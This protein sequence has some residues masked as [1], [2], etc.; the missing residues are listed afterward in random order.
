MWVGSCIHIVCWFF[1]YSGSFAIAF[2]IF[3][4][5]PCI[6][7]VL[8]ISLS[9]VTPFIILVFFTHHLL[10]YSFPIAASP[11][12][13]FLSRSRLISPFLS[14]LLYRSK[15]LACLLHLLCWILVVFVHLGLHLACSLHLLCWILFV[16][17]HWIFDCFVSVAIL[18]IK[19]LIKHCGRS[20]NIVVY[21]SGFVVSCS[22]FVVGGGPSTSNFFIVLP[23]SCFLS[24]SIFFV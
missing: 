18:W 7:L 19:P 12:L 21:F 20:A 16:F 14:A 5:C 11:L 2:W 10:L 6:G 23:T 9:H 22:D 8:F 24:L 15:H 1:P 3:C 17:V 13:S 4:V